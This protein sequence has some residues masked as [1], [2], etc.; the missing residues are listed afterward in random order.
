MK[1]LFFD[2][3]ISNNKENILDID[4]LENNTDVLLK[5][6]GQKSIYKKIEIGVILIDWKNGRININK[7]ENVR[8]IKI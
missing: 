5:K 7:K 1:I 2:I 6:T 4:S 8:T 3:V